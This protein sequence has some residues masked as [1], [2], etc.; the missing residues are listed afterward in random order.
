MLGEVRLVDVREREKRGLGEATE[1]HLEPGA[2]R[3]EA[4]AMVGASLRRARFSFGQL[5]RK[6]LRVETR[7]QGGVNE[8]AHIRGAWTKQRR[9]SETPSGHKDHQWHIGIGRRRTGQEYVT[10]RGGV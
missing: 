9:V 1:R 5:P 4:G 10:R 6:R 2:R 3:L 7:A 8:K